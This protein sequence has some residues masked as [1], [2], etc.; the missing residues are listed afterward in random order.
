MKPIVCVGAKRLPLRFTADMSLHIIWRD[1][2]GRHIKAQW[3]RNQHQSRMP[4]NVVRLHSMWQIVEHV[5]LQRPDD[6][7]FLCNKTHTNQ[8]PVQKAFRCCVCLLATHVVC[9][10][11]MSKEISDHVASEESSSL[12]G[13]LDSSLVPSVSE[14]AVE[15]RQKLPD[16]FTSSTRQGVTGK[17]LSSN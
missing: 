16:K 4:Y 6:T 1:T 11:E 7:C 17:V 12:H 13:G 2:G 5:P 9:A 14:S 10:S 8:V 15:L 3:K